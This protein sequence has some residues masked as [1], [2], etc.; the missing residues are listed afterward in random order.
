M[1]TDMVV[2]GQMSGVTVSPPGLSPTPAMPYRA[3]LGE[4]SHWLELLLK[5]ALSVVKY[6]AEQGPLWH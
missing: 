4:S 2:R 5:K 3:A 6:P 1:R